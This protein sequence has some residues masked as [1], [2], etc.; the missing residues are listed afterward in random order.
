MCGVCGSSYTQISTL[1]HHERT[2]HEK[3][4]GETRDDDVTELVHEAAACDDDARFSASMNE[5]FSGDALMA[6]QEDSFELDGGNRVSVIK[7]DD[8]LVSDLT[9]LS[10]TF[11]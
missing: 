10:H 1:R 4:T 3:K 5:D 8:A 7:V 2:K 6:E 11:S 9:C